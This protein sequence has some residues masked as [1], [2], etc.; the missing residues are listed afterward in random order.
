MKKL[1]LSL[2]VSLAVVAATAFAVVPAFKPITPGW[3]GQIVDAPSPYNTSYPISSTMVL[4][5]KCPSSSPNLCAAY[6]KS[7]GTLDGNQ[8]PNTRI[9][10]HNFQP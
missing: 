3:Y 5:S 6:L 4:N 10:N 9:S 7:D 8:S 2:A 1:R